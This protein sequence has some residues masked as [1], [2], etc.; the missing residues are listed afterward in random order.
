MSSLENTNPN[1]SLEATWAASAGINPNL[2][3]QSKVFTRSYALREPQNTLAATLFPSRNTYHQLY[4]ADK[5]EI[6]ENFINIESNPNKSREQ[7]DTEIDQIYN[8]LQSVP[9]IRDRALIIWTAIIVLVIIGI[10]YLSMSD[11]WRT[12]STLSIIGGAILFFEVVTSAVTIHGRQE[13]VKYSITRSIKARQG[14]GQT[15]LA[16]LQDLQRE[17]LQQKQERA[18]KR[19]AGNSFLLG[20]LLS[21]WLN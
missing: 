11:P 3:N 21:S 18:A 2:V 5:L 1:S 10:V 12:I 17:Q 14:A 7:K 8:I 13:K 9:K 19:G 15:T 6:F 16:T 20:F 4:G